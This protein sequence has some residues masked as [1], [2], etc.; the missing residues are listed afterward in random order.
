[1]TRVLAAIVFA[2]LAAGAAAE[3]VAIG[4][5]SLAHDPQ[6]EDLPVTGGQVD[7]RDPTVGARMAIED[8]STLAEAVGQDL[9]LHTE[10][11]TGPE[12]LQLALMHLAEEGVRFVI[13]DLPAE[14]VGQASIAA[15]GLPITLINAGAGEDWLREG[16]LA[17]LLHTAASDRMRAD[18]LAQFLRYRNW[19]RILILVG[20]SAHDN[21]VAEDFAEAAARL[22]LTISDR[23][24]FT[25][26][27]DPANR[28]LNNPRLLTG[29]LD[30]DVV[31]IADDDGEYARY[32]Q[33][34]TSLA[35][36]VIGAAG[37]VAKTWHWA[38]ERYGAPQVN[39]RFVALGGHGMTDTDWSIWTAVRAAA[40][41][42]A[43]GKND[44][45]AFIRAEHFRVDGSKGVA[46]T[47]RHWDGQLRMPMFL[48]T[49]DAVIAVAPLE[50]FAHELNDLDTLGTDEA[51]LQCS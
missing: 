16:C 44:P 5:L 46:L 18:A 12:D 49:A 10:E 2:L 3:E 9:R 48:G 29:G 33:Y 37:L 36:P 22:R 50:G 13:V 43:R 19:T 41:A 6:H 45:A 32:L 38:L 35:R 7:I 23:R 42:H 39:S 14:L 15:A 4:F 47:F 34:A 51:E 21:D 1:L 24:S 28:E 8:S 30:Y 20:P 25:L 26:A 31:F 17:N 27:A 40:T 11:V